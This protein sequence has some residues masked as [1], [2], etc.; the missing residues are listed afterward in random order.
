MTDKIDQ[1]MDQPC[2][3]RT[4]TLSWLQQLLAEILPRERRV[5]MMQE[6]T[7]GPHY[8]QLKLGDLTADEALLL[9][10]CLRLNPIG[11]YGGRYPETEK[12]IRFLKSS[13]EMLQRRRGAFD[14]L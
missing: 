11:S 1:P 4:S 3:I 7:L 6:S 13:L 8:V 12:D 14:A 10:R 2:T 9:L 5:A